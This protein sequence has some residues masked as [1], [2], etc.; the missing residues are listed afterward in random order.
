M[1]KVK[2]LKTDYGDP[3]ESVGRIVEALPFYDEKHNLCG[4]EILGSQLDPSGTV[5]LDP[6]F[7]YF[8]FCEEVEVV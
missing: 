6:D 5:R 8:F 2:V 3:K 4:Y 1:I 7:T